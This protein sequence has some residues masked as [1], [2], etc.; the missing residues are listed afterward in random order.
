GAGPRR[1]ARLA[2]RPVALAA[3]ALER[4][5]ADECRRA[6]R[7]ARARSRTAALCAAGIRARRGLTPANGTATHDAAFRALARLARLAGRLP[8]PDVAADRA[9][10][11]RPA[12]RG[13]ARRPPARAARGDRPGRRRL[14]GHARR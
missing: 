5:A 8:D 12:D 6:A 4:A 3:G 14:P 13:S 11:G 2:A 7:L 9:V 10:H 1:A